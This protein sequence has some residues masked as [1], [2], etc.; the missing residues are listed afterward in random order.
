MLAT[1]RIRRVHTDDVNYL[2]TWLTSGHSLIIYN[3]KR[4]FIGM[5]AIG[6]QIGRADDNLHNEKSFNH[7]VVDVG[8]WIGLGV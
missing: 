1:T 5:H 3:L 2:Y 4:L 7:R 8:T 6:R